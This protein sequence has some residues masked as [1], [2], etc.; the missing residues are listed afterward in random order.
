MIYSQSTARFLF[1]LWII[2]KVY[3]EIEE[4]NEAEENLADED[5]CADEPVYLIDVQAT[6]K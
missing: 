3:R 5:L 6:G 2:L 4:E 1:M